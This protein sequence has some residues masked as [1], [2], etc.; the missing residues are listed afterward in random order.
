M[1]HSAAG[2]LIGLLIWWRWRRQLD[3][4][5]LDCLPQQILQ[6]TVEAP[7][8]LVG[9]PLQGGEELFVNSK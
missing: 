2:N 4:A 3:A 8:I 6:L 9:P 7:Q 1:G 5:F